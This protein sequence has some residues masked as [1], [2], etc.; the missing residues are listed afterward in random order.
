LA[1]KATEFGEIK[2]TTWPLRHSRSPILVPLESPYATVINSNLHPILHRF[3]VMADYWS[4][5]R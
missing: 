5:F 2:Q 3:Q 4:H 1:T